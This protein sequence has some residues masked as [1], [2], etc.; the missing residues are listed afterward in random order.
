ML[1]ACQALHQTAE[2]GRMY[3]AKCSHPPVPFI[4]SAVT[5]WQSFHLE[6]EL[7]CKK[8]CL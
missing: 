3:S 4:T 7:L 1:K 5:D 2:F 6:L 8:C